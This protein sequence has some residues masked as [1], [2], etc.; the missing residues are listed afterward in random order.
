M[1]RKV[2]SDAPSSSRNARRRKGGRTR[3]ETRTHGGAW[4][5]NEAAQG[6]GRI[7]LRS[8][9]DSGD[10]P[11]EGEPMSVA[12]G[13][14]ARNDNGDGFCEV[15]VNTLEG[16]FRRRDKGSSGLLDRTPRSTPESRMSH[17]GLYSQTPHE[18]TP[19]DDVARNRERVAAPVPRGR[20]R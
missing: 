16:F 8:A 3:F 12:A 5:E 11:R 7:G 14:F 20:P 10:D 15:H 17:V 2:P 18:G 19:D 9:V 4:P 13:E 1:S 6:P